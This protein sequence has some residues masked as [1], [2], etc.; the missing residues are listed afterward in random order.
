MSISIAA[1]CDDSDDLFNVSCCGY[2]IKTTVTDSPGVVN[3]WI[4]DIKDIHRRRLHHLIVGLDV[5]W[6]PNSRDYCNPVATLQLCVGRICL[7][8]QLIHTPYIPQSLVEFLGCENYTFVGVGISSDVEKLLDD[9]NLRVSNTVDL[10]RLGADRRGLRRNAGLK[11]LA[12]EVLGFEIAKPKRVTRSRWD[13][14]C[15]SSE[16]IQYACV[17]AFVSFEVGRRLGASG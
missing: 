8:Y 9:Y 17:D 6:R 10:A 5:E 15:L 14:V 4:S 12:R 13:V 2:D 16:Q 7:I 1:W 11:E 3:H